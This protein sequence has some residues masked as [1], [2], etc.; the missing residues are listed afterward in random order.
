[1][2]E[3]HAADSDVVGS[4]WAALQAR[5]KALEQSMLNDLREAC[6]KADAG[7]PE[8]DKQALTQLVANAKPYGPCVA[9][10]ITQLE[11]RISK[12]QQIESALQKLCTSTDIQL[13]RAA[14][15]AHAAGRQRIG[16]CWDSLHAHKHQLEDEFPHQPLKED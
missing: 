2:L 10:E 8:M 13:V 14:L 12:L 5:Q 11:A 7:A 4:S 1:M 16:S 6:R 3:K 15:E 9:S